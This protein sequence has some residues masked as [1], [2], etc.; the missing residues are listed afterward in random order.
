MQKRIQIRRIAALLV[1]AEKLPL[2]PLPTELQLYLP[3]HIIKTS[4]ALINKRVAVNASIRALEALY[5]SVERPQLKDVCSALA[6]LI[7]EDWEKAGFI[8]R[9]KLLRDKIV[10]VVLGL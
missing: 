10:E 8:N 9:C 2:Q 5:R 7:Q 4:V 3:R 6:G 1:R